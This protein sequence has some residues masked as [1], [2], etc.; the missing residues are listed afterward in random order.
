MSGIS[1]DF[2]S[3][4]QRQSSSVAL[5]DG[6]QALLQS[7]IS[8]AAQCSN[9]IRVCIVLPQVIRDL[10]SLVFTRGLS[11]LMPFIKSNYLLRGSDDD[12]GAE[13]ICQAY[14]HTIKEIVNPLG[15]VLVTVCND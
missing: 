14:T 1:K 12:D 5:S 15:D 3:P 8:A 9:S 11:F 7:Y 6:N 13:R 4:E 10:S 2:S